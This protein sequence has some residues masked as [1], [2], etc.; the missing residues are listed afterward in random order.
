MRAPGDYFDIE[1]ARRTTGY[2]HDERTERALAEMNELLANGASATANGEDHPT[3]LVFGLPRSGTTA[4]YQLLCYCLDVGYPDNVV[5]RFW[6]APRFGVALSRALLR[7]ARDGSFR[8]EYGQSA[9]LAGPHEFRYFWQRWLGLTTMEDH[10]DFDAHRH[11]DWPGLRHALREMTSAFERPVVFKSLYFGQFL[12]DLATELPMPLF[13]HVERD[14][15]EVALSLLVAR[16]RYYGSTDIWWSSFPP[17]FRA[18]EHLPVPDQIAG[19]VV[20]LRR[21]HRDRL[22]ALSP[23]LVLEVPY[24]ELCAHPDRLVHRI[25]Q[26]LRS[27]YGTTVDLLNPPPPRLVGDAPADPGPDGAATL[28]ALEAFSAR[29]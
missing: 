29:H 21:L 9:A 28:E 26:Q 8:S 23:E 12:P 3:V 19:Q 7:G 18:L 25:R 4:V 6:E 17:E 16:Q 2:R 24:G 11:A 27:T 15:R 13:V 10:L 1:G 5:A 20:G 14:P 22:A